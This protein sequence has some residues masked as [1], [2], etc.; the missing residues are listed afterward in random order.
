MAIQASRVTRVVVGGS[1]YTCEL[2]TFKVAPLQFVD[3]N[4]E[5][6]GEPMG[7]AYEFWTIDR[8]FYTGPLSELQLLKVR[9]E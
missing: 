9:T 3:D 6:I 8:D 2:G 7:L 5:P 4:G 1:W